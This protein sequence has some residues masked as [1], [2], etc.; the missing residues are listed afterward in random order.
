MPRFSC[1]I[2]RT[3]RPSFAFHQIFAI[4]APASD[5]NTN[6]MSSLNQKSIKVLRNWTTKVCRTYA[7]TAYQTSKTT[8]GLPRIPSV[9]GVLSSCS[10]LWSRRPARI[11]F[12]LSLS[13]M[14]RVSQLSPWV[15]RQSVML[16]R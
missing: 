14:I 6:L 7:P 4:G 10:L 11:I 12:R 13:N 16:A 9:A 1:H 2:S 5:S 8:L 3:A 15:T